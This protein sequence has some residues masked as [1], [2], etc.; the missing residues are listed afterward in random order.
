MVSLCSPGWNFGFVLGVSPPASAYW[1]LGLQTCATY[2]FCAA[3]VQWLLSTSSFLA[4]LEKNLLIEKDYSCSYS[5][6][7]G[8]PGQ[9]TSLRSIF[10]CT[11]PI[12]LCINFHPPFFPFPHFSHFSLSLH[13]YPILFL[14]LSPPISPLVLFHINGLFFI[15]YCYIHICMCIHR[16]TC[17]LYVLLLLNN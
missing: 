10:I 7:P 9:L 11:S 17:M 1:M 6:W 13:H 12:S 2:N 8:F 16:H 4:V 5:L 15:N 3:Q 14:P